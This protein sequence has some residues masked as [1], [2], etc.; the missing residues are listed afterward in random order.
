MKRPDVFSPLCADV[1]EGVWRGTALRWVR[2][3]ACGTLMGENVRYVVPGGCPVRECCRQERG[4]LHGP[5]ISL[6]FFDGGGLLLLF[7]E[8][9]GLYLYGALGVA[10]GS[11]PPPGHAPA[12]PLRPRPSGPAP[13]CTEPYLIPMG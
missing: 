4:A 10:V 5:S 3:G 11:P 9:P 1:Q 12:P 7:S 13:C 2:E 8:T 6:Y